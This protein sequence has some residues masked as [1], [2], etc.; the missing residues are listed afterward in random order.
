MYDGAKMAAFLFFS[1]YAVMVVAGYA[2]EGIFAVL[3]IV[4]TIRSATVLDPSITWNYTTILNIAFM[5]LGVFLVAR[6]LRTGG[7]KMLAEMSSAEPS[8][9][10]H[11]H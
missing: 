2:I 8:H 3:R 10:G 7:P 11:H 5:I 9:S 4:P 1:F 6:F